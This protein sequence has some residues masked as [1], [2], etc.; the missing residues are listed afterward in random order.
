MT[1]TTPADGA[2]GV[3]RDANIDDHVQRAGER[4]RQ[5]VHD[6]LRD[7]RRAR[8]PPRRAARPRS[9]STRPR[10][11]RPTSRAR[12]PSLA[13]NVTDQDTDDPPDTM[14]ANHVFSSRPPT[15][16]SAATRRRASTSPGQ[17]AG[18]RRSPGIG[19][20]DRGRRRRRLPGDA[21]EFGGFYLQEEDGGRRRRPATSEGIFVFDN[22]FGVDVQPATSSASAAPSTEFFG[23]TELSV[24]ERGP[25]LLDRRNASRRRPSRSRSRALDRPRA[26][27]GHAR[28]ASTRR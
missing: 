10:T 5:L 7:E 28:A 23:L 12:S 15:C 4:G 18:E 16:S 17:P 24:G 3:A 25:G 9:R 26:L 21:G 11:S 6:Q 8:A 27:R 13:A 14:A 19:R 2:A 1:S 22:G 20:D